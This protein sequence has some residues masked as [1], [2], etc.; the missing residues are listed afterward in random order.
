MAAAV[1]RCTAGVVKGKAAEAASRAGQQEALG[2]DLGQRY[3]AQ[4]AA[5]HREMPTL[6]VASSLPLQP[7]YACRAT[8]L[9]SC[10]HRIAFGAC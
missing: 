3:Q 5:V 1:A 7:C 10:L 6:C 9:L 4:A 2:A 8:S